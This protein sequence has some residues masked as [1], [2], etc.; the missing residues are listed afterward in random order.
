MGRHCFLS[1]DGKYIYH[2][3]IIDYLQDFNKNKQ[4]ENMYKSMLKDGKQISAV[5]PKYYCQRFF[6]FMQ[7]QVV[8]NQEMVD[9]K[10]QDINLD[11]EMDSQ[12]LTFRYSAQGA[13]MQTIAQTLKD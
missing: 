7:N 1:E 13:K 2:L 5:E 12:K 6:Q 4:M 3:A 8:I 10:R 9:I 11:K